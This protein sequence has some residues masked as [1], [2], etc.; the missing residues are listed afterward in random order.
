[1]AIF[2]DSSLESLTQHSSRDEIYWH[3]S[4][5]NIEIFTFLI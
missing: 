1:L 5:T 4:D 3:D 2:A